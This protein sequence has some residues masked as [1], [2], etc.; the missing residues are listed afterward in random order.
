MKQ[1]SVLVAIYDF[2]MFPYA[3]GDI[4]TWNVRTAIDCEQMRRDAV[5]VYICIDSEDP[6]CLFQYEMVDKANHE[7]FFTEIFSAFGTHPRLANIYIY[8]SRQSM[9]EKLQEFTTDKVNG[10]IISNYVTAVE[11][12]S[13]AIGALELQPELRASDALL[14]GE[15]EVRQYF[16]DQL[17]SHKVINDFVAQA[18]TVPLLKTAPGCDADVVPFLAECAPGKRVVPFHLRLRQVDRGFGGT[19]SYARDSNFLEWYDF[20]HKANVQHPDVLFIALG[21]LQEKPLDVLRLPNVVSLRALGM[22]LGH[23][24]A[25]MLKSDFFIGTSSGFAA[26]ANFSKIPYFITKMSEG[27]CKAYGIPF[28]TDK[29]PFAFPNQQLI[30]E[31]ET[32]DLLFRLLETGLS[33]AAARGS[34]IE[35]AAA[36]EQVVDNERTRLGLLNPSMTTS[37]FYLDDG[38]ANREAAQFL[39]LSTHEAKQDWLN[40]DKAKALRTVRIIR[41]NFPDLCW[42][43]P[44]YLLPAGGVA[45]EEHDLVVMKSCL[46]AVESLTAGQEEV[47]E[48]LQLLQISLVLEINC[49]GFESRFGE[50]KGKLEHA[51]LVAPLSPNPLLPEFPMTVEVATRRFVLHQAHEAKEKWLIDKIPEAQKVLDEIKISYPS[52]WKLPEYL[53]PAGGVAIEKSDVIAITSSLS[54]I[55]SLIADKKDVSDL[56]LQLHACLKLALKNRRHPDFGYLFPNLKAKL[57]HA[58]LRQPL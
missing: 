32:S 43:L 1:D 47:S 30:Y 15:S 54:D 25:I 11:F 13:A 51:N 57:T 42:T 9:I 2:G 45:I 34:G 24:L 31:P 14:P 16:N 44:Q 6:A 4:L 40:G 27:A 7:I 39:L 19:S 38:Q 56:V 37:R 10:E 53:L 50:L 5:D 22:G 8:R 21:R 26:L 58:N 49:P 23:D 29:L 28:G 41:E 52:C 17:H 35:N 3:L 46:A 12:R 20:L 33:R 18:G 48:L 55:E 36:S